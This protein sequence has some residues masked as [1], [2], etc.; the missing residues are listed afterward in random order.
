MSALHDAILRTVAGLRCDR[1]VACASV[2][3]WG[4]HSLSRGTGC[5]LGDR[6]RRRR[7]GL[8]PLQGAQGSLAAGQRQR[9]RWV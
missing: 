8:Q 3:Q 5:C 2:P 1:R 6:L 4:A 9:P 7:L